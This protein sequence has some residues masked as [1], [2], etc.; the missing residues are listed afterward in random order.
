M[1]FEGLRFCEGERAISWLAYG[2]MAVAVVECDDTFEMTEQFL[3]AT[4]FQIEP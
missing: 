3:L 2:R 4:H 1:R